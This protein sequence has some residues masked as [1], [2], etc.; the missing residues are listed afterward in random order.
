VT[1]L[2]Y[3]DAGSI[4]ALKH[5]RLQ[6][7]ANHLIHVFQH[8][9]HNPQGQEAKALERMLASLKKA[10]TIT[11][12]LSPNNRYRIFGSP[13]DLNGLAEII[14]ATE[15][16]ID[17]PL[18]S[19]AKLENLY[20]TMA[21]DFELVSGIKPTLSRTDE[22]NL[23]Q[24]FMAVV[25]CRVEGNSGHNWEQYISRTT[26]HYDRNIKPVGQNQKK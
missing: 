19:K 8:E 6:K 10:R 25:V 5:E 9:T 12:E 15:Q 4:A 16:A 7:A 24:R 21:L 13:V 22:P 20:H 3:M 17:E 14:K 1:G 26:K 2:D 11:G 23:F 18:P